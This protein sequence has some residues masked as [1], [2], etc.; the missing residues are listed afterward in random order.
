MYSIRTIFQYGMCLSSNGNVPVLCISFSKYMC[1]F[2]QERL[3]DTVA[4]SI[5]QLSALQD[6]MDEMRE[7]A[8]CPSAMDQD[9]AMYLAASFS[10][11]AGNA[12]RPDVSDNLTLSEFLGW[13]EEF[14][15]TGPEDQV[16][17]VRVH[18]HKT[19]SL[20]GSA[21]ISLERETAELL[22]SFGTKIV[23]SLTEPVVSH[24]FTSSQAGKRRTKFEDVSPKLFQPYFRSGFSSAWAEVRRHN[25]GIRNLHNTAFRFCVETL[26]SEGKIV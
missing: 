11:E 24:P 8:T 25:P 9:I 14:L 20:Y 17:H 15:K 26:V 22:C 18:S 12:S 19:K 5:E 4:V 16:P 1:F 23:E 7:R 3:D 21:K 2:I 6:M 13:R 10:F